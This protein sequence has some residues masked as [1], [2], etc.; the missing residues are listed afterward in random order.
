[1]QIQMLPLGPLQTNCY[2]LLDDQTRQALIFD[3][4]FSP[5]AAIEALQGY[6]V[7]AIILTHGHWDHVYGVQAVKNATRAPV[8]ISEIEQDWLTN[9]ML[10]RSGYRTDLLKV[11]C[12]GPA[13][14]RLLREGETFDFA[15]HRFSILHT[16]GHSPGSLSFATD[17]FVIAG[18]ALFQ[19]SIGRTDLPGGSMEALV[20][21]IREKL[22]ALPDET[23]VLPGHG[24]ATTIGQEKELNPFVGA[25]A[26]LINL[27]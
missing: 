5:E 12:D 19:R 27:D 26:S 20:T 24:P 3:P 22:F 11:V 7:Q 10:N 14:D 4:G 21:A 15:G 13:P 2:I 1:M 8:W 6:T 25:G 23:V 18:D 17:G 9:P 16:P